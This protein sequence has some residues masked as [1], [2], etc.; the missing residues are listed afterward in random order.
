MDFQVFKLS[1]SKRE[2]T[3]REGRKLVSD[4]IPIKMSKEN[5]FF[6]VV[7]IVQLSML[8]GDVAWVNNYF[9]DI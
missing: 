4:R 8:Q 1:F 7:V 2:E 3:T 5:N 9:K 6:V